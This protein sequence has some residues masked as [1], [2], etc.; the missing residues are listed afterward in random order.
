MG[1]EVMREDKGE[2]REDP[3]PDWEREKVAT[4]QISI[5]AQ[6]HCRSNG[7]LWM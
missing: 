7:Q 5:Q 2:G 4:L 6:C 3:V 1:R